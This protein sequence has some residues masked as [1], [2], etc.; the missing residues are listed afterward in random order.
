MHT[1]V[2]RDWVLDYVIDYFVH[3]G[4]GDIVVTVAKGRECVVFVEFLADKAEYVGICPFLSYCNTQLIFFAHS[5]L[6]TLLMSR[7]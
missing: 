7:S 4:T 6:L 2:S 3:A 1:G 5:T